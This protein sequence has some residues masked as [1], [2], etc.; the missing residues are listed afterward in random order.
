MVGGPGSTLM[1]S[2]SMRPTAVSRSN[3]A[4]GTSVAPDRKAA[5]MPALYPKAWKKGLMQR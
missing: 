3:T 4:I 1:R 5:T 2:D